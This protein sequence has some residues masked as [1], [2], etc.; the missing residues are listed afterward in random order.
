MTARE[1]FEI[2]YAPLVKRHLRAI[3]SKHHS[4]I[5]DEI[6]AQLR[7]EPDAETRNRKPLKRSVIFGARWELRF[8]PKNRFR[9]F[10]RINRSQKRVEIL[11]IGEKEGAR[12]LLGGE[13]IDI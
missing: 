8:G 13:E 4:L 7:V 11:A 3:A 12:L 5:R 9:V 10:Y 2:I 6:E 1:K